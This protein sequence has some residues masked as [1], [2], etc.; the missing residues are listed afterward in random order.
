MH[1][2]LLNNLSI[3]AVFTRTLQLTQIQ[4]IA[5][6]K[7]G[8]KWKYVECETIGETCFVALY[9]ERT[10]K[11]VEIQFYIWFFSSDNVILLIKTKAAYNMTAKHFDTAKMK[12]E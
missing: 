4:T 5:T 10:C 3:A 2:D 1:R 7:P 11:S 9:V 12:D 8:T 6:G